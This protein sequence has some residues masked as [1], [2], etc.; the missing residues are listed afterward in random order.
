MARM[1]VERGAYLERQS[2]ESHCVVLWDEA[3]CEDG[4]TQCN[5]GIKLGERSTEYDCRELPA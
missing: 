4:Q 2:V 5:V 1:M 3:F